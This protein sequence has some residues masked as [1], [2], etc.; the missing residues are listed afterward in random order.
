VNI[1][2]DVSVASPCNDH[3]WERY[4]KVVRGVECVGRCCR[5]CGGKELCWSR[6]PVLME[7]GE[8]GP[9]DAGACSRSFIDEGSR[10]DVA[11]KD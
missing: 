9:G 11:D 10:N 3:L 7:A 1:V 5:R 2:V 6:R 4:L 8:G